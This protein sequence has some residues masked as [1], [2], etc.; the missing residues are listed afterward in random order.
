MEGC[1]VLTVLPGRPTFGRGREGTAAAADRGS[2]S[3]GKVRER[4]K[5]VKAVL[6]FATNGLRMAKS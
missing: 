6:G 5:A 4:E 1:A 2:D 3:F